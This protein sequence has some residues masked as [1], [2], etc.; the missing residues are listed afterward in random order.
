[1]ILS[2]KMKFNDR[3]EERA[4]SPAKRLQWT[5]NFKLNNRPEANFPSSTNHSLIIRRPSSPSSS[6]ATLATFAVLVHLTSIPP[7]SASCFGITEGF[8]TPRNNTHLPPSTPNTR[9]HR[10]SI[11][12]IYFQ[13]F[14]W[15]S[16]Q[17]LRLFTLAKLHGINLASAISD[18]YTI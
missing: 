15:I 14:R 1:M 2:K 3:R 13:I 10:P 5:L 9:S 17:F 16:A 18:H 6:P 7:S 12:T 8:A 11:P 4:S